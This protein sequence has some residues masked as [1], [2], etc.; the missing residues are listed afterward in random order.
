[1]QRISFLK[2]LPILPLI[3]PVKQLEELLKLL[4]DTYREDV[5]MPVYFVGHGDP[6]H[7][8]KD[9]PFTRSLK[10]AGDSLAVRPSAYSDIITKLSVDIVTYSTIRN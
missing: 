6:N 10:K 1:M 8:F 4:P 3:S 9:N 2:A 5:T 7:T